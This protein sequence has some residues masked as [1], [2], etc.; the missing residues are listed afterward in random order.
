MN[1]S[2]MRRPACDP[3]QYT[4]EKAAEVI[5]MRRAADLRPRSE[6]DWHAEK[7]RRCGL[8]RIVT[9]R[10]EDQISAEVRA[11]VLARDGH[12]C[13]CCGTSVKGQHY[14]LGHRVRASQGGRPVPSNLI[15]VLGLGG[16]MC[17]GR[18]DGRTN[19]DD[20][21]KGYALYSWQDP[22][23]VAVMVF[24]RP[25]GLGASFYLTDDG[26]RLTE[27]EWLELAA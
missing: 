25:D 21:G 7:C 4:A 14:S 16:E 15:T 11:L 1:R 22:L 5:A 27:A 18:I 26:Q 12:R 19:R 6:I 24:E 13:V 23:Q 9:V 3:K 2:Q 20:E 17:H 10:G 8:Y